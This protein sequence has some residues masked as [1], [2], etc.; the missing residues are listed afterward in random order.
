ML[1]SALCIELLE[2]DIAKDHAKLNRIIEVC[3]YPVRAGELITN[4]SLLRD[5]KA[6]I[7]VENITLQRHITSARLIRLQE[8]RA[9]DE[10]VM[11]PK[12]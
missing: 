7:Q 6:V 8:I 1:W 12:T 11:I 3:E 4:S 9:I 10:K 2:R 5:V